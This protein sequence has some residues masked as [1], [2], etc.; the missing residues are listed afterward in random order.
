[1]P[2]GLK[3]KCG[4]AEIISQ[5]VARYLGV[6][7]ERNRSYKFH[8]NKV[9]TKALG[10]AKALAV[11]A[12][13]I[14]GAGYMARKLYYKVVESVI[15]YAA[16]IWAS[17][18][19]FSTNVGVLISTQRS[20]LLKMARAYRTIS[21][22]A[23]S[24]LTGQIPLDLLIYERE[25][26]FYRSKEST[27]S[28]EEAGRNLKKIAREDTMARWQKRWETSTKGRWTYQLIPSI[29]KWIM[30]GPKVLTYH[31]TQALTGHG[32][33]ATYLYKIGKKSTKSCWF[34][35]QETDDPAHSL[36]TCSRWSVERSRLCHA[37][38]VEPRTENIVELM[39]KEEHRGLVIDFI[40]N[41]LREK[42]EFERKRENFVRRMR[43]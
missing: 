8:I 43:S 2:R 3:V 29:E 24:I 38:G 11:L 40:T 13:N 23:L 26:I 17:G 5:N 27:N 22:D 4:N 36:F 41:I 12:P 7:F 32:C 10:Y 15:M 33:F 21:W 1:M 18:L 19:E 14:G 9:C 42:E 37:L 34:C 31:V 6:H 28:N 16:P 30:W 39:S 25:V 20:A 35:P